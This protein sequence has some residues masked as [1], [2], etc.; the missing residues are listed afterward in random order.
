[1][2]WEWNQMFSNRIA[3]E[4]FWRNR[5]QH[6]TPWSSDR[7]GGQD[8]EIQLKPENT[9][10][11]RPLPRCRIDSDETTSKQMF[12]SRIGSICFFHPKFDEFDISDKRAR[13]FAKRWSS[14]VILWNVW[15]SGSHIWGVKANVL[16]S[17]RLCLHRLWWFDKLG[18][19]I[20][21]FWESKQMF[22]SRIAS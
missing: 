12:A 10:P 5:F 9:I 17:N 4:L 6:L 18:F 3:S 7:R 8:C 16:K 21:M 14:I 19:L 15:T 20:W 13:R 2:F 11:A 22:S 1:M